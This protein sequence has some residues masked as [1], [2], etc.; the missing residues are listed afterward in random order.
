MCPKKA[1]SSSTVITAS[2]QPFVSLSRKL[3]PSKSGCAVLL[4]KD[5]EQKQKYCM[6][7]RKS[8]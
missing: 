4:V 7:E 3:H 8:R 5:G 2:Q 1:S 6:V